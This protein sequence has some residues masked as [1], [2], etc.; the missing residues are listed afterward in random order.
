MP[1]LKNFLKRLSAAKGSFSSYPWRKKAITA[2]SVPIILILLIGGF[3]LLSA[4]QA[5]IASLRIKE[6]F[7]SGRVCRN[8]CL[9][10]RR[11]SEKVLLEELE[12]KPGK[13]GRLIMAQLLDPAEEDDFKAELLGL[14]ASAYGRDN[15]PAYLKEQLAA[16]DP[17]LKALILENFRPEKEPKDLAALYL[18]WLGDQAEAEAVRLA[19]SD[20]LSNMADKP[21]AF[22]VEQIGIIRSLALAPGTSDRLRRALVLLLG[23]YHPLFPAETIAAWQDLHS[24]V[25]VDPISRTFAADFLNRFSGRRDWAMPIVS[26]EEWN[27]YYND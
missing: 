20:G 26:E 8:T 24:G 1:K 14:L 18:G 16:G 27:E 3:S 9:S 19:A 2:A 4:S 6:T 5:R 25:G 12:A 17:E 23:D 10:A 15:P 22:T 7:K 21:A 11:D 13:T